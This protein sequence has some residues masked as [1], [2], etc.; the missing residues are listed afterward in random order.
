[1]DSSS[2]CRDLDLVAGNGCILTVEQRAALQVSLVTL[3]KTY[4][5]TRVLFWG[6]IL[7]LEHDYF[8]AQ[9]RGEHEMKDRKNLYSLNCMDWFLL[10]TVTDSLIEEVS[11]AA[12]GRF[13]GDP[14]YVHDHSGRSPEETMETTKVDEEKRLAVTVHCID[15]DVSV[16]P[17]GAFIKRPNGLVQINRCF[18][19]LSD[20]EAHRL[21]N[22]VH[23]SKPKGFK[24]SIPATGNW[25]PAAD[26][27]DTIDDD[28]PKGSWS[29]QFEGAGKV[30]VLRSLLWLGLTFYHVPMT[31][32][33]G[34]IYIGDG[35][36]NIDLPFML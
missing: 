25:S 13:K 28:I 12:K 1:M 32:Q 31:P 16:V 17:R 26:F 36:K 18:G 3:K 8:I 23:F 35:I 11:V 14:S 21:E 30:C 19:G 10:P 33:H 34:Y 22:F 4:K 15:E 9:G 2:L 24:K 7:G 27:L 6:K 20:S 29:L 5:F